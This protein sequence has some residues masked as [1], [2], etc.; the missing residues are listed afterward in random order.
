MLEKNYDIDY[1]EAVKRIKTAILQSRYMAARLANTEQLKLYFSIGAY[2]S[3]N[4]REGK[5]E[6]EQ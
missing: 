5:W 4:S 2:V 6:L 3:V 1:I